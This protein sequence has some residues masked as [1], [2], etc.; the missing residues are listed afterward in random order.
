MATIAPETETAAALPGEGV[1][2]VAGRSPRQLFWARFKKDRAALFGLAVIVFLVIVA[3]AAPLI[4]KIVGHGPN[5]LFTREMT[6][7]FG[8]PKG[9][10]SEF[11]F[12]ADDSGRD[13][14]RTEERR[15]G[16]ECRSRWSPYH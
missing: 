14:F 16:K 12:G 2:A 15:V 1:G 13:L 3:L 11:W 7:E 8:L 6:D 5:D 10:N 4:S 9:P